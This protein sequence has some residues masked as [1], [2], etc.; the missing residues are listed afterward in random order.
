MQLGEAIEIVAHLIYI[1]LVWKQELV[2][3]HVCL[4]L[5]EWV[6]PSRFEARS[7]LVAQKWTEDLIFEQ[8][9]PRCL[10]PLI[11]YYAFE[12]GLKYSDYGWIARDIELVMRDSSIM[13]GSK[14]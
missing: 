6:I 14:A 12:S 3:I 7:N 10:K 13:L 4:V 5:E 8:V 11:I 1:I 2:G 9:N